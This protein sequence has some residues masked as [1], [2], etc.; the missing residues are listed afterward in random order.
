[1]SVMELLRGVP[2]PTS[3]GGAPDGQTPW[4]RYLLAGAGTAL[5]SSLVVVLPALIAWVA[6]PRSTVPW[7]EALGVGASLWLLAGGSWLR[8]GTASIAFVPLL[9]SLGL[10]GAATWGAFRSATEAA[11]GHR[12]TGHRWGLL[13]HPVVRALGLWAAGYAGC[14]ALWAA[15]AAASSPRPQVLGLVLPLLG[16]PAVAVAGAAV[17]LLSHDPELAGPR[18]GRPSFVPDVVRRAVRPAAA[19]AGAMLGLGLATVVLLVVLRFGQVAHLHDALAPGVV[20][21]VLLTVAQ[22]LC[23]PNLGL[24]A[25]SFL[26][27][28]GF[29]VV[30]GASTTWTG[31]RSGLMPMVPVLGALPDPGAFPGWLPAL[32]LLPVGVGALIGWRSLR[33]LALLS[34]TRTKL[35]VT[36]TAVALAAGAIGLLDAVAGGSLGSARLADLGAPAGPMALALLVEFAVGAGIVLAWDRWRLRR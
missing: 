19:G 1:M 5:A 30:E 23:L 9:L 34:T 26:A 35:L 2:S 16:V 15:V 10:V 17:R 32:G 6:S 3:G 28:T 13:P 18:W 4:H 24:W 22:V 33:S 27:G 36:G 31:S 29:S 7:T 12:S 14:A 25:V 21:G 8:A 11:D 20:G